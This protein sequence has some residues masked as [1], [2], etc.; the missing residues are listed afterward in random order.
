MK[1]AIGTASPFFGAAGS[2]K[3]LNPIDEKIAHSFQ[4]HYWNTF[5]LTQ[6]PQ[7]R[8]RSRDC[9]DRGRRTL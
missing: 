6:V 3:N 8:D 7:R 5:D 1:D 9:Q 2:D 4:V